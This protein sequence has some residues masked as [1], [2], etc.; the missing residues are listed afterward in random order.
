MARQ[1]GVARVHRSQYLG[2][3]IRHLRRMALEGAAPDELEAFLIMRS[4]D[5][6][7]CS[8]AH[9]GTG[10]PSEQSLRL[11]EGRSTATRPTRSGRGSSRKAR[12]VAARAGARAHAPA[13][14]LLVH[15]VLPA[16][17]GQS[18]SSSART[19]QPARGSARPAWAATTGRSP[20]SLASRRRTPACSLPTRPTRGSSALLAA[21]TP[22]IEYADVRRAARRAGSARRGPGRRIRRR[23]F[24]RGV[25]STR[26]IGC[27]A[28]TRP[29]RTSRR[30]RPPTASGCGRR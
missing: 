3:T 22:P 27:S 20:S 28:S 1:A 15:A 30:G 6:T 16:G 5:N 7:W 14:L 17:E 23:G 24:G 8:S 13:R 21:F 10:L 18:R 11:H 4:G 26:R 12:G 2:Q 9:A 19:R 29:R 25:D